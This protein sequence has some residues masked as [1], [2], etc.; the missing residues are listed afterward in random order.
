MHPEAQNVAAASQK[1]RGDK[2]KDAGKTHPKTPKH[3]GKEAPKD[4]VYYTQKLDRALLQSPEEDLEATPAVFNAAGEGAA[5]MQSLTHSPDQPSPEQ[6]EDEGDE[7]TEQPTLADILRAVH[8]CTES[9]N[10]LQ[11]QFGGLKEEVGL[12][13]HD[14]QKIRERTTAAEGQI[15]DGED[16]LAPL[17]REVQMTNRIARASELKGE[18]I[19]NCLRR[20]NVL[21]VGL[22][23]KTE[24]RDPTYFVQKWLIEGF[25]KEAFTPF[26]PVERA[27]RVP[28][29]ES[30]NIQYNGRRI[31]FHPDFSVEDQRSRAKFTE[32]KKRLQC[33][34][35]N[36]AML[37]PARLRVV[38]RGKAGCHA[39]EADWYCNNGKLL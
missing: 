1:A 13:C 8:K 22:P 34:Q 2:P 26:Y 10:T 33:H 27:H 7:E 36:Y 4:M 35:A 31:S 14:L 21:I 29:R 12:I 39:V 19:E 38:V 6:E 15:S 30:H 20:S 11:E 23:E 9:V 18:D 28:P 17:I 3:Q 5:S 25:G 24:G 37:Y 32:V 16:K